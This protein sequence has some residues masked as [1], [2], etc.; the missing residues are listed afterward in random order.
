[1]GSIRHPEAEQAGMFWS[2]REGLDHSERGTCQ[3]MD[4][5]GAGIWSPRAF[6]FYSVRTEEPPRGSE[7][8][9]E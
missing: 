4:H 1:M 9:S 5:R 2:R 3:E 8:K 6:G 7:Q